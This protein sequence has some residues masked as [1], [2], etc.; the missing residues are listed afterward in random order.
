M[1]PEDSDVGTGAVLSQFQDGEERVIAYVSKSLEGTEQP[2]CTACN[3][4]LAVVGA[5]KHFKCYL[6]GQ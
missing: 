2:Y 4:L 6:Y 1:G 3:E 5:L